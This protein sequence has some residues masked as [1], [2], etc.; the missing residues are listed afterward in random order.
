MECPIKVKS[1]FHVLIGRFMTEEGIQPHISSQLI[2]LK[3]T[4]NF[5]GIFNF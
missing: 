4:K 2:D 5:W 3:F 1:Q